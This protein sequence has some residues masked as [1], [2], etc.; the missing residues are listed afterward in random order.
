MAE[1]PSQ[2]SNAHCQS[3]VLDHHIFTP[4]GWQKVHALKHPTLRLRVSTLKKDY[5]EFS[6][7]F[8][9]IAPKHVDVVVDSGAQSCLWSR[10]E[11]IRSGFNPKDLIPVR[12]IMKAANAAPIKIDGAILLRLSGHN[13]DGKDIE[14]AVMTYISPDSNDFFISKEAM[15]QLGIIPHNFPQLGAAFSTTN[16]ECHAFTSE[17]TVPESDSPFRCKDPLMVDCSCP[18]RELPPKRPD[19]LPFEPTPANAERMKKWLLNFYASSTFNK[20]PHQVLPAM[21]GPPIQIHVDPMAKP[22]ALRTAAPV[23]LHWQDQV[24]RDLHRDVALGVLERVPHGEPTKWCFRMVITRKDD[25]GPRRT[26]DL[27]PLNKFCIREA[28]SSQSPFQLA[29]SVPPNSTKTVVDAWNGYHSV[30]IREED[31]ILT[32]FTTPWGLFRYKRAPQGFLSSGDGYNRR[33]DDIAAHVVRM[34]R[35]VDDCLLHDDD[36]ESHWW[37]VIELLELTGRSGIVINPEKFQFAQSTVDFAGFRISQDSVEPLPKYI[38]AI[39]GFPQPQNITDIRS[40]FGLVNQVSHYGQ[41]RDMMEPYRKFLSPKVKFEWTPELSGIFEESKA[42]IIEAIRDGVRIFDATR[43]TCL[44]TDWSKQGIGYFLA[45][46]HCDCKQKSYGCCPDGW[47]ITLAGSRFLSA[48]ESNYAAIEGEALAVAWALEQ[49]R[50]FTMGCNNL[51]VI[52][53]HKP[54]TKIFGDRRLD[55]IDN[56]RLFR[57]KR[58][59]LMWRF[60]IE[61]KPG[62]QNLFA[63]ATSRHPNQYAELASATLRSEDNR[64]E[65]TILAGITNDVEKFFAVTWSKVRDESIQD[66]ATTLL[67]KFIQ[68]GFPNTRKEMP[69][70]VERYWEFREHLT[71]V[72][73][74]VLYKDRIIV[75]M[76]LRERILENLHS[77]HQGVSGMFLR[78]QGAVFWPGI[79]ADI[80][81]S[82]N[83]CRTCHSNAPSQAKMPPTEPRIPNVPFECIYADYFQLHGK[84]FLIIGDRLSGWTEV[85]SIKPG[86]NSSGAKGLCDALHKVYVTFG[87]PEELSNDGGS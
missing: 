29:R 6:V 41:L 63:D 21:E 17:G 9:K 73:G 61:Y 56:P 12:H 47:K 75:P 34:E 82:R 7:P 85:T 25:G 13:K 24:Q 74:V 69:D 51:L 54:L 27:S 35:C 23:P 84:H 22:V 37:R 15:I 86:S 26:V 39:E 19:K 16:Y 1:E 3:V 4:G 59:T 8:P 49:T 28:H 87:V 83:V 48:T 32:T 72:D 81:H 57:M 14:A 33:F 11:F 70:V 79:N 58:R 78:A 10:R 55:E 5:S 77:A 31:R 68:N 71:S 65:E 43:R 38:D 50:F 36:I 18:K 64:L 40:W 52:V 45:Q 46:Q 44:R 20:C 76:A 42:Q 66:K 80:E 30:P 60:E 2:S 53:D 62:K 67:V